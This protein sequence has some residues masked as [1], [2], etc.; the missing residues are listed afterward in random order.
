[1]RLAGDPL[2]DPIPEAPRHLRVLWIDDEVR[3]D[4]ALLRLLEDEDIVVDVAGT[5]AQGLTRA[6]SGAYDA[7]LVDLRLPD[8]YGLTVV[9]RLVAGGVRAAVLVVTGYYMEP[10]IDV[11]TRRLGAAG[12][13]HK[14]FL[15]P[16]A[17]RPPSRP[18]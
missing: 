17:W 18:V 15:G 2:P 8:M 10:E 16:R 12:V 6:L 13:L 11:E 4:D 14:P 3:P 7:V 1:M 9:R 5:G